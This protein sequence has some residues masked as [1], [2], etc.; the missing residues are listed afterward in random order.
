[1]TRVLFIAHGR[2]HPVLDYGYLPL[3]LNLEQFYRHGVFVDMRPSTC[4]DIVMDVTK[5]SNLN[6]FHNDFDLIFIMAAPSCVLKSKCFWKNVY[7]WL[8]PRGIVL[9]I[10]PYFALRIS[11]TRRLSGRDFNDKVK[12]WVPRF[13]KMDPRKWTCDDEQQYISLRKN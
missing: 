3:H 12:N 1:M 8:A 2:Q 4:P 5:P 11:E 6:L 9:S 10:L 13:T 7:H